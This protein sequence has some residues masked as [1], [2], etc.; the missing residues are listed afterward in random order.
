MV[1]LAVY[2]S[3]PEEAMLGIN[4]VATPIFDDHGAC[5]AALAIVGSIQFLPGK[6]K[7]EDLAALKNA[8]PH[9]SRRLEHG[10]GREVHPTKPDTRVAIVKVIQDP[11]IRQSNVMER[12]LRADSVEKGVLPKLPKILKVAGA[13]FV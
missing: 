2:A 7:P 8:G 10:R 3:A 11:G 6:P 5:V 9:I 4:A 1:T 12:P 13:V